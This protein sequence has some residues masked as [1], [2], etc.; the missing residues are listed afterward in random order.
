MWEG[1]GTDFDPSITHL[2]QPRDKIE[3]ELPG[4]VVVYK[5]ASKYTFGRFTKLTFVFSLPIP[6]LSKK[7]GSRNRCCIEQTVMK[8][9][10]HWA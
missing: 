1:D 10:L 3:T 9:F 4:R 5:Y 6:P 8:L 2:W 7:Y